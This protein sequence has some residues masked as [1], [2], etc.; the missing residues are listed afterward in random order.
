MSPAITLK[1]VVLPAPFGPRMPRRSPG[2]TSRSTSL[3]AR[4][5]PKRRPTPRKRRVG[6]TCSARAASVNDLLDDLFR[7]HAV[8]HDADLALPRQARLLAGGLSATGRLAR[9]LEETV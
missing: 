3:T 5:P 2:V 9:A 1:S 6:S 8:L 7:D 4:R